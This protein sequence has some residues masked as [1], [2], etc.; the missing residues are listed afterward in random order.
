MPEPESLIWIRRVEVLETSQR[1][2]RA[3]ILALSCLAIVLIF[4]MAGRSEEVPRPGILGLAQAA[5]TGRLHGKEAVPA[6][7]RDP[8]YDE[9]LM[10]FK[11]LRG[12][13]ERRRYLVT[14]VL[15]ASAMHRVDP[16]LLFAIIAA[17]SRFDSKAVSSKGARGLGQ[18]MFRTARSVAPQEVR[19]PED[20]HNVPRNLSATALHLRQL[21]DEGSGDL[22][23]AL[24]TY[25]TGG[26]VRSSKGRGDSDQYVARVSIYYASLKARRV[27]RQLSPVAVADTGSG[28]N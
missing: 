28:K 26:R 8:L 5:D 14:Q 11:R 27:Y 3:G 21:M 13:A 4:A 7:V 10:T 20:L 12:D 6:D 17:E 15:A 25:H 24:R 22:R 9:F 16:D 18:L 2:L 23:E 19:R 1:R